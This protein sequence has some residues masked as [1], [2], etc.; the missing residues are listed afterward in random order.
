MK[1]N[2]ESFNDRPKNEIKA[3]VTEVHKG[4]FRVLC[5]YGE[6]TAKLK[7]SFYHKNDVD[8]QMPVVG[9]NVWI[10][11][12]QDGDSLI[13]DIGKRKSFFARTD[14][15]GH[16]A[17]YVKTMKKQVLAANFDTV[18]ILAS[19]N[20][21]FNLKRIE[22]YL[23]A[24][25]S[26][27]AEAVILLT[28]ADLSDDVKV[29]IDLV[30]AHFGS[31]PCFAISSKTGYGFDALQK[32]LTKGKIIVFLGSSGVGKSSLVNRLVSDEI[33]TVSEIREK[34]S[35]GR[36]TTS[37]RQLIRLDC[38]V[39]IIDTPGMRELGLW[40]ADIGLHELFSDIEEWIGLCRFRD[41]THQHEPGCMIQKK[42][43]EGALSMDRWQRYMSMQKEN[44]WGKMKAPLVKR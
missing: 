8:D 19:L 15:S 36:H 25:L 32:Y 14:F 20:K 2:R 28:K 34:D 35:R 44:E 17:G 24:A 31:I 6:I 26:A 4:I 38:G 16:S 21:E 29:Y 27:K 10:I 3:V 13:T 43:S 42:L 12:N 1:L 39:M 33:M 5:E 22:R 40:D 23:A 30:T 41:C 37:H 7:G 11:F 18:F 9:D